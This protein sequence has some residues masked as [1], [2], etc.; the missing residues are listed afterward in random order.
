[1]NINASASADFIGRRSELVALV[2]AFDRAAAGRIGMVAISGEVGVGK[3]RLVTE[4]A[5]RVRARAAAIGFG[6]C[7]EHLQAPFLPFAEAFRAL[8]LETALFAHLPARG[9]VPRRLRAEEQLATLQNL[10]RLLLSAPAGKPFVVVLDDIQWADAAT[11][12]LLQQLATSRAEGPLL[13]VLIVREEALRQPKSVTRALARMH[14]ARLVSI[15]LRP[16]ASAEIAQLIR[17]ASSHPI[18]REAAQRIRTLSEGNPL[19]AEGL[20][21]SLLDGGEGAL[22]QY[23]Y[24]GIRSTV[25]DRLY[26]LSEQDQRVLTCA[27]VVGRFFD[28]QLV[29][30]LVDLPL[31]D[32]LAALRRARNL[33]L[34][35]EHERDRRTVSF[36]HAIFSEIVYHELLA[37]EARVLHRRVAEALES[38]ARARPSDAEIA[39][40]WSAAGEI[41]RARPAYL[42]AGD[43]AL[44]IC[45]FED[46]AR[47]YGA[48]L[49][50]MNRESREYAALA[51]RRAY[52]EYAAGVAERTAALFADALTAYEQLGERHKVVEMLL[53]LSRQAWNDAETPAGYEHAIRAAEL[54]ADDEPGLREYALTMAAS[55]AVHLGRVAEAEQLL[56]DEPRSTDLAVS[57]RRLDV[58][59]TVH[60]R[61]GAAAA[62]ITFSERA[63]E[64]ADRHGDPDLIV[65]CYTN[66]GDLATSYGRLDDACSHW[67]RALASAQA[68]GY[69]GRTAYAA[70]GY[71]SVL[72]ETGEL[73]RAREL[74]LLAGGT[75][76][77]NASVTIQLAAVGARLDALVGPLGLPFVD[78]EDAL[79][80]ALRSGE[81]VRIGQLGAALAFA[82]VT[83]ERAVDAQ[84]ILTR[85]LDALPDSYF[86]ESLLLLAAL[87]ADAA[88]QRSARRRLAAHAAHPGQGAAQLAHDIVTAA[89]SDDAT[90]RARLRALANRCEASSQRV[91]QA[92]LLVLAQDLVEAGAL[93]RSI[94]AD[95]YAAR[96]ENRPARRR[97]DRARSTLTRREHEVASL[98]AR[99][100][101]NRA[102]AATL[103]IS[104]R[105]TEHHVAAVLARLGVKSRWLVTPELI[106]EYA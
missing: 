25:L 45:A 81:S 46:A 33:D 69:V 87:F 59:S 43:A 37:I 106:A 26:Q 35:R 9:A 32:V 49:D 80:F 91:T 22:Y 75:G 102:I 54:I 60:A 20:L 28:P 56:A 82:A 57:A 103:G 66:A 1:M 4:L 29:S 15:N 27:A 85:A 50:G 53:F 10:T 2:E 12:G 40:H 18:S 94:G 77:T 17:A 13:V 55:Y 23:R 98:I 61:R 104:A 93:L 67:S 51:E 48:A 89:S 30:R 6:H 88:Q 73:A 39:Y 72:I 42:C 76:V 44:G 16:L 14:A 47:A 84:A 68:G 7:V 86:A 8:G 41:E 38:D 74:Y 58:A 62:A 63:R 5:A 95:A 92:L 79:R 19:V 97:G 31:T 70:L 71:A 78:P 52:A 101:T 21:K 24:T 64:V 65:R 105:T 96:V 83:E 36:R 34:V 11:L 100:A 3:S 99:Q 90:R